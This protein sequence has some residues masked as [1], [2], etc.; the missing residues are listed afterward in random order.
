MANK[1]TR[2]C[3]DCVGK[4][5]LQDALFF[6][7]GSCQH[8]AVSIHFFLSSSSRAVPHPFS[9]LPIVACIRGVSSCSPG[10]VSPAI[11]EGGIRASRA[12]NECRLLDKT[13]S[14]VVG[15]HANVLGSVSKYLQVRVPFMSLLFA[16]LSCLPPRCRRRPSP[17]SPLISRL[18]EEEGRKGYAGCVLLLYSFSC[19]RRCNGDGRCLRR[20][21]KRLKTKVTQYAPCCRGAKMR[22][23]G[24]SS[25]SS[26]SCRDTSPG[27]EGSPL[28]PHIAKEENID[29]RHIQLR[30]FAGDSF[31]R[32]V[33]KGA[34]QF[35]RYLN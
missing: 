28:S 12:C 1:G 27:T 24:T 5:P 3:H 33:M 25:T 14:Y 29:R 34:P 4:L 32:I 8:H 23:N 9:L 15:T 21:F 20:L 11:R 31:E 13:I 7:L 19:R 2:R 6:L 10:Q 26:S 18:Y 17:G 30:I 22:H 35:S 16:F